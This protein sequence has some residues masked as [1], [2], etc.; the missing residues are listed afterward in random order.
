MLVSIR[1]TTC[2]TIW[3]I[4]SLFINMFTSKALFTIRSFF[5]LLLASHKCFNKS[6]MVYYIHFRYNPT[7][8]FYIHGY[9]ARNHIFLPNF[10][11]QRALFC[12]C[13]VNWRCIHFFINAIIDFQRDIHHQKAQ[14]RATRSILIYNFETMFK[15]LP[16]S[17]CILV[18]GDPVA[19]SSVRTRMITISLSMERSFCRYLLNIVIFTTTKVS[20]KKLSSLAYWTFLWSSPF[21]LI[22]FACS[23]AFTILK[24]YQSVNLLWINLCLLHQIVNYWYKNKCV[25]R[26][27]T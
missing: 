22:S 2:A 13:F 24:S 8:L 25:R 5:S 15:W 26:L 9:I 23:H 10:Q 7:K 18:A 12:F 14:M 27:Q 20:Y 17:F 6:Y 16:C 1:S 4:T 21:I 19:P 3:C 11:I